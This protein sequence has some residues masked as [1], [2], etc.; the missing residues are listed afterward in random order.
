MEG[1]VPFSFLKGVALALH[2]ASFLIWHLNGQSPTSHL[3]PFLTS[4]LA[5]EIYVFKVIEPKTETRYQIVIYAE[6]RLLLQVT[7]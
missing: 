4:R 1:R 7:D 3:P 6:L 2:L 5:H